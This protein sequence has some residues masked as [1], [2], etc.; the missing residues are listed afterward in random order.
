MKIYE[1]ENIYIEVETSEIP[2]LKIFPVKKYK[3]LSDC[4]TKTREELLDTM[5]LV[6]TQMIKFYKP[7]K[8]NIAMFGNYLPHLHIHVMARFEKDSYFPEPMWGKKQR[9]GNLDLP[10]SELFVKNLLI[11]LHKSDIL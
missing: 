4:D 7:K 3:E 8:V 11:D 9:N 5:L 1:N 10:S 2:W 6:E